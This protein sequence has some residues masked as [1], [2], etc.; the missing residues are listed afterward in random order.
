M[1]CR[2]RRLHPGTNPSRAIL[3]GTEVLTT[4]ACP[5]ARPSIQDET[6][7]MINAQQGRGKEGRKSDALR[8]VIPYA[9]LEALM[10]KNTKDK[11]INDAY[12]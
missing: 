1:G 4:V 8:H 3:K 7:V 11:S 9:Y 2:N 12:R 10:I 5:G 6:L